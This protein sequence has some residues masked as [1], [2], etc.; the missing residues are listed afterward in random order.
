MAMIS[1][2]GRSF[3]EKADV[4]ISFFFG[5]RLVFVPAGAARREVVS[6]ERRAA[7]HRRYND[8]IGAEKKRY[9]VGRPDFKPGREA[10][11]VSGGFDS[12]SFPPNLTWP[13]ME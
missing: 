2:N 1:K 12:H 3:H 8:K 4:S 10:L 7:Q 6:L 13:V 9:P 11:C 5:S